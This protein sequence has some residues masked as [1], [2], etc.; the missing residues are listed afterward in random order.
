VADA[1]DGYALSKS[2]KKPQN[3]AWTDEEKQE[4]ERMIE[5]DKQN[6]AKRAAKNG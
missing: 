1:Y 3:S 2:I 4:I 5:M 6:M